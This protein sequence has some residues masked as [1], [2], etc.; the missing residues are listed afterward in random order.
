MVLAGPWAMGQELVTEVEEMD[1]IATDRP[2]ITESA[3][4]TPV[5]WFQYEG[6]YQ[7]S[8]F[9]NL[10]FWNTTEKTHQFEQ[11]FRVGLF[12]NFEVRAVVN[13]NTMRIEQDLPGS[14]MQAGVNPITLGFKYNL[15]KESAVLPQTTWLSHVSLPGLAL[16][17]Y[18]NPFQSN[19]VFHEQRLMVEKTITSRLGLAANFGVSGGLVGEDG[20]ISAGMY[21][22]AVG[23]DLG[24]NWG[25][26]AEQFSNFTGQGNQVDTRFLV[27]GGVTKLLSNDL[28]IDAYVGYDLTNSLRLWPAYRGFIV[29]GGVS[30]RLPFFKTVQ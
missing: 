11:V 8:Q 22:V 24:N 10:N 9:T 16:G 14:T 6:G 30:Y 15:I 27:D 26:Y 4:I 13:A 2:D 25:I 3:Q 19:F 17:D 21:S 18:R 20:F 23:F 1:A 12:E 5:G 28:Q 7:F 29:G